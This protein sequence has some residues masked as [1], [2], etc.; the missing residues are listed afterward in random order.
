M[1]FWPWT[2][3]AFSDPATLSLAETVSIV[4]LK[5]FFYILW[6]RKWLFVF[7]VG[8]TLVAT[9]YITSRMPKQYST[10]ATLVLDVH[11]AEPF[12]QSSTGVPRYS[13]SGYLRT[14]ADI[15]NS[16]R[17]ALKAFDLLDEEVR[18]E[19]ASV[20]EV[21]SA[22]EEAATSPARDR[23]ANI[24]L[25]NLAVDVSSESL[26]LNI[27]MTTSDPNL[28]AEITNAFAQAY[29]DVTLELNVEPARRN[30]AWFDEQLQGLRERLEDKQRDL[31]AY[32]SEKGIVSMDERLDT[33]MQQFEELSSS[34]LEAQNET[35]SVR[36]RQLGS[37]HPEYLRALARERS[38][39]ESLDRQKQRVFEVRQLRDELDLL[40]RDV[41]NAKRTYD[42]A[43]QKYYQ[44]MLKS[45][46]NRTNIAVLNYATVPRTPSS[47]NMRVNLA[48]AAILGLV[49]GG[50]L[51]FATELVMR[52]VRIEEDVAD[53][54]GLPLLGTI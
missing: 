47:P 4:S 23:L 43:L 7:V 45:Q 41:D 1:M 29:M 36:S 26:V 28:S 53:V 33:E 37:Q 16:R 48:L 49:F 5:L 12:D 19:L 13:T 30:A 9:F 50:G 3:P 15:I 25:D 46:F 40:V 2:H 34:Y 51:V 17:V 18:K 21:P 10:L 54:T 11:E 14:Q 39:A 44:D 32:Q 8:A 42:Q 6:C 35:Y 22:A 27:W 31:T 38:I 52:R 24:L 20:Y